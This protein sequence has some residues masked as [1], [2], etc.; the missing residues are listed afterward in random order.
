MNMG[1]TVDE[2]VEQALRVG[3]LA[4]AAADVDDATRGK[5]RGAVREVFGKF[6]TP[7]GITPPAACWLVGATV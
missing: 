6:A 3:P 4:R 7:A 2:A 1:A 5:V